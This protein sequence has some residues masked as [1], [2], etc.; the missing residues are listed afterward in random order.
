MSKPNMLVESTE[1]VALARWNIL[2]AEISRGVPLMEACTKGGLVR[3]ELEAMVLQPLEAERWAN[4]RLAGLRAGWSMLDFDEI[5]SRMAAAVPV[6]EAVAQVKGPEYVSEFF[7]LIE[8]EDLNESF[9]RAQRAQARAMVEGLTAT[10]SD[11]SRDILDNGK[12]GSVGNMAS[13]GRSKLKVETAQ[14]L[15]AAHLP[16]VYGQQKAS[17]NV[18]VNVNYAEIL[19]NSRQRARDRG[20]PRITQQVVDAAFLPV[21]EENRRGLEAGAAV[22]NRLCAET[23]QEPAAEQPAADTFGLED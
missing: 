11:D 14:W 13:V 18:Q 8:A 12:G 20:K 2:L 7:L 22:A 10:A 6:A 5:F 3:A 16:E 19:E 9:Q 21:A 1:D 23:E 15:L 17:T 4:A